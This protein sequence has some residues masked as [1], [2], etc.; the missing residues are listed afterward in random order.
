MPGE[1][2]GVRYLSLSQS[3][4]FL[5]PPRRPTGAFR[6]RKMS[7]GLSAGDI[8]LGI[9]LIKDT[10]EAFSSTRGSQRQYADVVKQLQTLETC[11]KIA[12]HKLSDLNV[13]DTRSLVGQAVAECSSCIDTYQ[14]EILIRYERFFG[15][16]TQNSSR[17]RFMRELKKIQWLHEKE[18][19]E[20]LSK[21]I[22]SHIQIITLAC[23]I[24]SLQPS[25]QIPTDTRLPLRPSEHQLIMHTEGTS[26]HH[27]V[28]LTPTADTISSSTDSGQTGTQSPRVAPRAIPLRLS[29]QERSDQESAGAALAES[30]TVLDSS[31]ADRQMPI[32]M[33]NPAQLTRRTTD[34]PAP[35]IRT[36]ATTPASSI[37]SRRPS[38]AT[39]ASVTTVS[40][41][42]SLAASFVDDHGICQNPSCQSRTYLQKKSFL[43]YAKLTKRSP[44]NHTYGAGQ[45]KPT[46]EHTLL[47]LQSLERLPQEDALSIAS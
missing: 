44:L 16:E 22:A 34:V 4:P 46:C 38:F 39:E 25:S 45:T 28:D 41:M 13:D 15:N 12:Q 42:K 27:R 29:E 1:R 40:T 7:F 2:G 35:S 47:Y 8:F 31:L 43:L 9:K 20:T 10:L 6:Q 14:Q 19:T 36:I 5:L 33:P 23:S 18:K 11:L 3:L 17:K 24:E 26:Q 37:F 32:S 30:S 21:S